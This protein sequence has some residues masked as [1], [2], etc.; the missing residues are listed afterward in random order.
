[1][2]EVSGSTWSFQMI[3]FF[4]LIFACFLT[5][6]LTYSKAYT[7]KNRMLSIIEKYEGITSESS[8]ILN[9]F[10]LKKSYKTTAKC[11]SDENWYGALNL[12]GDY[13]RVNENTNYYYCFKE[14]EANNG[15]IFY[16]IKV[17]YKF[18]LPVLG[19]IMTYQIDGDTKTFIGA[20]NRVGGS[21]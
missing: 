1:M 14:Q 10:I 19:Q 18:N 2:R 5:L 21:E 17:F 7:I 6:V 9:S 11:P 20:T 16:S 3:I 13:E 12:S 8:E 15:K 4:M